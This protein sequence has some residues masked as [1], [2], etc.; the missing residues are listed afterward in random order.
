[1][2]TVFKKSTPGREGVWP[3][4]PQKS[5]A[6]LL[7]AGLLRGKSADLPSLSELDVVRH[8][9]GLSKRNYG[10]DGNF[11]PLGSCTM[12]TDEE[13][14]QYTA[15]YESPLG[16]KIVAGEAK[17]TMRVGLIFLSG[18]GDVSITARPRVDAALRRAGIAPKAAP[19]PSAGQI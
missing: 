3:T 13:V 11:Y 7:P 10:V 4:K 18:L 15:F 5:A 2:N 17:T 19:A 16:K 8:F 1:M 6:E 14:K 12:L 9:T